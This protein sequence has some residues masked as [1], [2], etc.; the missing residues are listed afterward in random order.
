[1]RI[2][3]KRWQCYDHYTSVEIISR[4]II[5]ETHIASAEVNK[6]G[7]NHCEILKSVFIGS[8]ELALINS[9]HKN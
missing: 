6:C 3:R 5:D 8:E 1:M 7:K 2:K 9:Y 4:E